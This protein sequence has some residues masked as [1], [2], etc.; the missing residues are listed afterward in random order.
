MALQ[1]AEAGSDCSI[2]IMM[3]I[4]YSLKFAFVLAAVLFALSDASRAQSSGT[5]ATTKAQAAAPT[6]DAGEKTQPRRPTRKAATTAPSRVTVIAGQSQVA[7]QVVTIVHR[8]SG[9][10][11]LRYL[12]RQRTE[13]DQVFTI[14]P[15][16]I[17]ND[18]H[19]SIIAGWALDDGKTI[20]ARLPQ[21]G[22][23]I[24]FGQFPMSLFEPGRLSS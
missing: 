7:P 17:S 6:Q 16:A 22:A 1:I 18:A 9:V 19:A 23:E 3:K 24:E 4:F 15:D 2:R 13:G 21:A 10:K 5:T 8:L 20:A 11:M 12:L 14:D